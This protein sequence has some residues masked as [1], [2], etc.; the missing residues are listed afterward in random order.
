[1]GPAQVV[2][3]HISQFFTC[4]R[5][6]WEGVRLGRTCCT[7]GS[8]EIPPRPLL[9]ASHSVTS[10]SLSPL[11]RTG[12]QDLSSISL[13]GL[14]LSQWRTHE[15][16]YAVQAITSNLMRSL[17]CFCLR[18][19]GPP[20]ERHAIVISDASICCGH[21]PE[22]GWVSHHHPQATGCT[23]IIQDEDLKDLRC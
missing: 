19:A 4:G 23:P 20:Q 12:M 22:S 15:N 3:K 10:S 6:P 17:R 8:V 18:Q 11:Q 2:S 5:S 9:K 13:E 21:F 14:N 7:S 16:S 1:M